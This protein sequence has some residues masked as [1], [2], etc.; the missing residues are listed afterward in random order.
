MSEL[1]WRTCTMQTSHHLAM[2]KRENA[3]ECIVLSSYV[4][5]CANCC[6]ALSVLFNILCELEFHGCKQ[7]IRG[8][9]LCD[10]AYCVVCLCLYTQYADENVSAVLFTRN[11]CPHFWHSLCLKLIASCHTR[12]Q[13]G[14]GVK[15]QYIALC[16]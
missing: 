10:C 12:N 3:C 8:Q 6:V 16:T 5:K 11:N 14:F 13:P 9:C 2:D 4:C 15:T 7:I 1:L